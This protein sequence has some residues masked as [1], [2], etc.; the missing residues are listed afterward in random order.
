MYIYKI[1][2]TETTHFFVSRYIRLFCTR[3]G[4]DSKYF[5]VKLL[6]D[7]MVN[8]PHIIVFAHQRH[9]IK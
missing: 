4:E 8:T 5:L 6:A 9:T 7:P 3:P 1:P 2:H